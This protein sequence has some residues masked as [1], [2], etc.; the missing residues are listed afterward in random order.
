MTSRFWV[1]TVG[2]PAIGQAMPV[3]YD[4]HAHLDFPDFREEA[5]AVVQR[6]ADAGISRIVTIGT[7]FES[8]CR[9]IDLAKCFD[10]VYAAVG[11]HPNDCLDAPDDVH[12]E[13]ERLAKAPKV[14]AIGEIGIDHYRLPS[15]R[16][17]SVA[18]D[19]A[20]KVRQVSLFRQQLEVAAELG[21]NVV[22]HQRAA[23]E[24]CLEVFEPFA[25]R[26]RGVFHCF[27]NAPEEA[28]RVIEMGS[29]VSF[30]GICTYKNA[31]DVRETLASVPLDKLMLETDAPFLAPVPYRGKRCEPAYVREIS[32][33]AAETLGVGLEELSGATCATARGFF[34]GLE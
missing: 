28:L 9:A 30:T 19:E 34:N 18:D 17:G 32:Q 16:G 24:S 33:A 1:A 23:F 21:L 13:L 25:D 15:T 20:F 14:V 3:F 26:V 8:S 10:G 12:G 2:R 5:D 22:V 4:T 31:V 7:E 11:W 27:V 29:L 6:A